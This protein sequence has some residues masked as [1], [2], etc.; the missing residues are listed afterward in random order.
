MQVY[1]WLRSVNFADAQ[2]GWMV[3]GFGT[4]L[5]TSDGGKSWRLCLG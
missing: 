4:I 5:R 2:N 3:G 1:T